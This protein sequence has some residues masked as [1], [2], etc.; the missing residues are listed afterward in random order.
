MNVPQW[1]SEFTSNILPL[2]AIYQSILVTVWV[3]L[4]IRV[5]HVVTLD[6]LLPE[7]GD[8]NERS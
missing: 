4:V 3:L 2:C 5:D 1:L 8:E 7:V 6:D